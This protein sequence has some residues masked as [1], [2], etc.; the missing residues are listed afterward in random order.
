MKKVISKIPVLFLW[1]AW[2]LLTA[3]SVIPHDHH[4]PESSGRTETSCPARGHETDHHSKIP[5]H[6]HALNV[7]TSE[8]VQAYSFLINFR[9]NDFIQEDVLQ[10]KTSGLYLHSCKILYL[11]EHLPV[12]HLHELS[13]FRAPPV[14]S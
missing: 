1:A 12:S 9:C 14:L 11:P 4:S 7:L 2:I 5:G 6:C 3:H 10:I 13:P 8:K